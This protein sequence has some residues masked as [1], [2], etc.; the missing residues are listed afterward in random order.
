[1]EGPYKILQC[2]K[3]IWGQLHKYSCYCNLGVPL[4]ESLDADVGGFTGRRQHGVVLTPCH[5][6]HSILQLPLHVPTYIHTQTL[7]IIQMEYFCSVCGLC[8]EL[9]R[10]IP[11]LASTISFSD[12]VNSERVFLTLCRTGQFIRVRGI[13][14]AP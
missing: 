3:K 1:M 8:R 7:H 9:R 2:K 6:T 13:S 4:V 10:Y 12:S 14:H 11:V 5:Q